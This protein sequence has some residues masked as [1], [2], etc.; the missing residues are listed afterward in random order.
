MLSSH[1]PRVERVGRV[2]ASTSD[3][4]TEIEPCRGGKLA[5]L[6]GKLLAKAV[7]RVLF[8]L[9]MPNLAL[10][11]M[12]FVATFGFPRM[13]VVKQFRHQ[14]ERDQLP[15][16]LP[17]KRAPEWGAEHYADAVFGTVGNQPID[18]VEAA[19]ILGNLTCCTN[20]LTNSGVGDH[21]DIPPIP[22]GTRF[23]AW[24]TKEIETFADLIQAGHVFNVEADPYIE[25]RQVIMSLNPAQAV[26]VRHVIGADGKPIQGKFYAEYFAE[27]NLNAL[28][29]KNTP[30]HSRQTH[31]TD[32]VLIM[33]GTL[34]AAS[35]AKQAATPKSD[36]ASAKAGD[37]NATP[38]KTKAV[39]SA[40]QD[41]PALVQPNSAPA[42]TTAP[43]SR[44]AFASSPRT[45]LCSLSK[46]KL[47]GPEDGGQPSLPGT[48][49]H[50]GDRVRGEGGRSFTL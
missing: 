23:K 48:C 40:N 18:A 17:G 45:K 50:L 41:G 3:H 5:R 42:S 6:I 10:I 33:V 30:P 22:R 32:Q 25:P 47:M 35:R 43:A 20:E 4:R 31:I 19:R 21:S 11:Q 39:R 46:T 49:D 14:G 24:Y 15:R 28:M 8:I 36:L 27:S 29:G 16:G 13:Q 7:A 34:L 12:C 26:V 2:D 37:D 44:S 9:S 1:A 38:K